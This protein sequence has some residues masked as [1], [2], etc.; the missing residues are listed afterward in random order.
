[1]DLVVLMNYKREARADQAR[2]FDGWNRFAMSVRVGG[3]V[4][5]GTALYINT[6]QENL[7]QVRR[8]VEL[9]LD[10]WVGYSYRTPELGVEQG[11]KTGDKAYRELSRL[12]VG[13][14]AAR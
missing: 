12:L 11:M 8:T 2:E 14:S 7:A 9:G 10:G 3:Q 5:A 13:E 6:A 4:A 1:M